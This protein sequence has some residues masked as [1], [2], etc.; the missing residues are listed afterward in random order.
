MPTKQRS[1][2]RGPN[3]H[4]HIHRKRVWIRE[5]GEGRNI[6]HQQKK[7]N[8]EELKYFRG[9]FGIPISDEVIGKAP[10][11][12]PDPDSEEMKYLQQ[13]RQKLGGYL[14]KRVS[15]KVRF[16]MPDHSDI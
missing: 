7:L 3:R 15:E 9:R 16:E 8:E 11:Y 14:P 5:A 10:F 13:Q 4:S 6:T 12:K 2:T 1:I